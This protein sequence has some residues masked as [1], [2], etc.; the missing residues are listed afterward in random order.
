MFMIGAYTGALLLGASLSVFDNTVHGI[1]LP[2]VLAILGGMVAA[3]AAGWLV[4]L[5]VY[6]PLRAAPTIATLIASLRGSPLY[7]GDG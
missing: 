7:S 4:E 2:L 1:Q 5:V 3:G 6:W